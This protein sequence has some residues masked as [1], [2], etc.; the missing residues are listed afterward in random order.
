MEGEERLAK[1]G[2]AFRWRVRLYTRAPWKAAVVALAA[3]VALATG[4]LIFRSPLLGLAGFVMIL[5]STAEY[6]LGAHYSV[7]DKGASARVGLSVTSMEW[8]KVRRVE[9]DSS[10]VR[11]SPL[12]SDTITSPFRGVWLRF[13]DGNREAVMQEIRKRWEGD[14]RVLE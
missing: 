5:A 11:L 8:D 13:S 4:A 14:V 3:L 2:D 12:A 7:D 10:G 9:V 6:W 1:T